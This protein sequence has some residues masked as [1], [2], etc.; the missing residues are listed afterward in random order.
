MGNH[1]Y[2]SNCGESDFHRGQP[3]DPAKVAARQETGRL[4]QAKHEEQVSR[5][6]RLL[7]DA[8][9]PYRVEQRDGLGAPFL[10]TQYTIIIE[11]HKL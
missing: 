5:A 7:H 8:Q 11:T 1:E 4:A 3:C 10:D 9:I 6:K 2:C